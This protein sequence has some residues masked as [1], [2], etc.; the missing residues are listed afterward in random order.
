MHIKTKQPM[1]LV[2]DVDGKIAIIVVIIVISLASGLFL[3]INCIYKTSLSFL[4]NK[5]I[6]KQL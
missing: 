6:V 3:N 2:G 5:L 1:N 4:A